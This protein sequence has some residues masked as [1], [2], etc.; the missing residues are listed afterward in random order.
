MRHVVVLSRR[1]RWTARVSEV[2][3]KVGVSRQSVHASVDRYRRHRLAGLVDQSP[4]PV[5]GVVRVKGSSEVEAR[6]CELRRP[7]PRWG[8]LRI[9][10]DL[11]RRPAL[12]GR[13]AVGRDGA[14]PRA[15]RLLLGPASTSSTC[16]SRRSR[17][18]PALASERRR[19]DPARLRRRHSH[20]PFPRGAARPPRP[21]ALASP[22]TAA[23]C[24]N[25]RRT[26]TTTEGRPG[27]GS[28]K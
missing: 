16:R 5:G 10:H 21:T 8:A 15:L 9:V 17:Q 27:Y 19:P 14:H 23:R 2:A 18:E 24:L 28:I 20:R 1:L 26:A 12:P 4:R 22:N 13:F 3:G 11:M 7:D 6:V 25:R